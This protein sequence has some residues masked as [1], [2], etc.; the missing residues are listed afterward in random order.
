MRTTVPRAGSAATDSELARSV[1][2]G[3]ARLYH[4]VHMHLPALSLAL[5]FAITASAAHASAQRA[6]RETRLIFDWPGGAEAE[7]VATRSLENRLRGST[8]RGEARFALTTSRTGGATAVTARDL[9]I[10]PIR[11]QLDLD[12][13]NVAMVAMMAL[14]S[15]TLTRTGSLD[16]LTDA[17]SAQHQIAAAL[18][19]AVPASV[20]SGAAWAAV[21]SM[22]STTPAIERS[23]TGTLEML[24]TS[25][26]SRSLVAGR[27]V[28]ATG[29]SSLIMSGLVVRQRGTLQL[30]RALPCFEGDAS[31]GCV[32]IAMR[33]VPEDPA[34]L[35]RMAEAAGLA[36]LQITTE[37][38]I[39]TEPRTL[40][41]HRCEVR[42]RRLYSITVDGS[43]HEVEEI[44]NR[45]WAFAWRRETIRAPARR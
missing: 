32:E 44:E 4:G 29:A 24:L 39:V 17:D 26:T 13:A 20:R 11:E 28:E 10:A 25:L 42:T 19:R 23:A 3:L 9:R 36:G 7:V 22:W 31:D 5:V 27:A 8:L 45:T 14:P 33:A 15:M 43:P 34:P 30:N 18:E 16:E 37:A 35:A 40:L 2:P 41:P 21:A 6:P 38:R 1:L 12:A